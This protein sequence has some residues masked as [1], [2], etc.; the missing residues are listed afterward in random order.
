MNKNLKRVIGVI[1]IITGIFG[2]VLPFLQGIA[3]IIAGL[4]MFDSPWTRSMLAKIKGWVARL[5]RK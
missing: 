5:R 3:L 4:V 1:L 2:L